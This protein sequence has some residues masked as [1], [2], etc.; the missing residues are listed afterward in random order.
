MTF[1]E[2]QGELERIVDRLEGGQVGLEEAISLW[3]RGEEL[4]RFCVQKL[5]ASH[6]RIEELAREAT[7][8]SHGSE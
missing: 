7:D 8:S 2:A 5:D 3:Q 4:Y 1:E 6:G